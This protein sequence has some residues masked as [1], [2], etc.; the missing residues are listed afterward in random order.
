MH[1]PANSYAEKLLEYSQKWK[2][3]NNFFP[4]FSNNSMQPWEDANGIL[5]KVLYLLPFCATQITC[6]K[7]NLLLF[8][9]AALWIIF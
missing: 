3:H 4:D 5:S 7:A 1:I 8:R 6:C 9:S 2:S